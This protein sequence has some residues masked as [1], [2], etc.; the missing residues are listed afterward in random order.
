MFSLLP[1]ITL[2]QQW[3]GHF[4]RSWL[5]PSHTETKTLKIS[6]HSWRRKDEEKPTFFNLLWFLHQTSPNYTTAATAP[7]RNICFLSYLILALASL[8]PQLWQCPLTWQENMISLARSAH[9]LLII[10]V[11]QRDFGFSCF[12]FVSVLEVEPRSPC[13]QKSHLQEALFPE[14]V[15]FYFEIE[16]H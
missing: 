16:S 3:R 9:N 11:L 12:C 15:I 10:A 1:T 14:H 5:Y 13:M 8:W 2:S 6:E 4:S 7:Q